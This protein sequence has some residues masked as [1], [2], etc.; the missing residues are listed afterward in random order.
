MRTVVI[1][2]TLIVTAHA[3]LSA[4]A[5]KVTVGGHVNRM[6]RFADRGGAADFIGGGT[7]RT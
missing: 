4:Q 5:V 3:T 2:A 1:A 7:L 6:I